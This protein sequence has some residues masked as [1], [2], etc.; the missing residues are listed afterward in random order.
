MPLKNKKKVYYAMVTDDK[1]Q[2]ISVT[3]GIAAIWSDGE[4]AKSWCSVGYKIIPVHIT[5]IPKNKKK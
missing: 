1:R 4:R 5:P 2:A 3:V